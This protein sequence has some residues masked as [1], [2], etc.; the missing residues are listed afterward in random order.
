MDKTAFATVLTQGYLNY[1]LVALRSIR[2]NSGFDDIP[3]YIFCTDAEDYKSSSLDEHD[4]KKLRVVYNNIIV[5]KVDYKK[6]VLHGKTEP[7]YWSHEAFNIRGFDRIIFTDVDIIC[8]NPIN[9]VPPI[10]LGMV[11]EDPRSQF[12]GGF[13]VI[14]KKH[15]TGETYSGIMKHRKRPETWGRDQAVYNE[16]FK[17]MHVTKLNPLYTVVTPSQ[18]HS[19]IVSPETK[20][21]HYIY[22]PY[23]PKVENILFEEHI[24]L[25][26]KHLEDVFTE[27]RKAG[28]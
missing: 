2:L 15:L 7:H 22:K 9:D 23:S 16:F 10:D 21:L 5:K 28:I 20:L 19:F 17:K 27:L 13:I 1:A 25:W 12:Y 26:K 11:W 8:L 6:Y 14:G 24:N 18:K 4:I 3:F